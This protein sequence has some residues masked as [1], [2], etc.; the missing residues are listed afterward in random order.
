MKEKLTKAQK[1]RYA[2]GAF[3]ANNMEIIQAIMKAFEEGK[4]LV[5]F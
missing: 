5:I 3:N 2:I 1:E 4:S